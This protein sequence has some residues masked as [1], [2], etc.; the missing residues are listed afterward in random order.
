MRDN[1]DAI[2]SPYYQPLKDAAFALGSNPLATISTILCP[3]LICRGCLP[4]VF[5]KN[6]G[7]SLGFL[8]MKRENFEHTSI[9][10]FTCQRTA[11]G[12]PRLNLAIVWAVIGAKQQFWALFNPK[13]GVTYSKTGS[14]F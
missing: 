9:A 1:I 3:L 7:L 2:S 12:T 13:K 10:C 8:R 14:N 11:L 6:S 5:V 4:C